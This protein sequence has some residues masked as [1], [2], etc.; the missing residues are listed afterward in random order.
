MPSSP[1]LIHSGLGAMASISLLTLAASF[2]TLIASP[3]LL[4]RYR[5]TV[6]R[7]MSAQAG[8]PGHRVAG[9]AQSG[10]DSSLSPPDADAIQADPLS[11][12][13]E[14][15]LADR[16]YRQTISEPRRHARTHALAG[17][18]FA[19][20]VGVAAFF[21]FSQTQVNYLAAAAHPLQFMFM[22]WTFA[23]PIVLTTN[24]VAG[25]RRRS[26]WL[27]VLIYFVILGALGGWLALTPTEPALQVGNLTLPAWSGET[28]IRL[29]S[30]WSLF[31]LG[32]TL[33]IVTF[34]HRQVRAV[35]PLVLSFMTVV[36]AGVLSMIVAAFFYQELS[37]TAIASS[38][39]TFG[40]SVGAA[41]IGYFLALSTIACLLSGVL[42]WWLLAWMRSGYQSKMISDQSLAIDAIWLIFTSFYAVLLTVAGPAWALSALLAF[43]IFRI[44]VSIGNKRL[45]SK[46]KSR[47]DGPALLVLRVFSLGKRSEMLFEAVTRRWRYVGNVRLIAGTDLALSTV[48][49]HQFLAFVSGKLDQLFVEGDA[50]ID[51]RLAAVDN[52]RDADGRFR[53]NDFFCHADTWQGVLR[54][55]INSTDVVLMDL[56]SLTA[57]NA[58][59]VYEIKE[60]L[61]VMPL[62]QVV[63]VVDSMTD[64]TFLEQTWQEACRELRRESPNVGL[65]ASALR[66]FELNSRGYSELQ[67]LLRRICAAA[68]AGLML[69]VCT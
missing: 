10:R 18:L 23:W 55:L 64:R 46:S 16:L 39:E 26:Q 41:L 68:G 15:D 49:P 12:S 50:A 29:V 59:C 5:R 58:G 33:L 35:A 34:R 45:R 40:V 63:F 32:P 65:T 69:C 3:W 62:D 2:L 13:P 42:G 27:N 14:S 36:S 1:F 44:A 24:I 6:A 4:W 47:D 17:A 25:A 31:N 8:G 67:G 9:D 43:V 52:R 60:L 22:F 7:L 38:S 20:V 21:A 11:F 57:N 53:I 37:V 48:A 54:K 56:R 51:G 19:L 61:N 66:P 30:K 28:P